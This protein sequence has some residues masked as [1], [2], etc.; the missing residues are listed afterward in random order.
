MDARFEKLKKEVETD[1]GRS[2]DQDEEHEL[3]LLFYFA[4]G[5]K[6]KNQLENESQHISEILADVMADIRRRMERLR[7]SQHQRR[8]ISAVR[9]FMSSQQTQS[10]TRSK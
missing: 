4:K 7:K 10:K 5:V 6:L 9:D 2:V 3:K 1:L 8:V